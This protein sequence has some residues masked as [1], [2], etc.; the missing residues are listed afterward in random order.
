MTKT[1]L[2]S[3]SKSSLSASQCTQHIQKH[4]RWIL[5]E[6]PCPPTH[7]GHQVSQWKTSPKW[8]VTDR[9][10]FPREHTNCTESPYGF[11]LTPESWDHCLS[12]GSC[13]VVLPLDSEWCKIFGKTYAPSHM[14]TQWWKLH[15]GWIVPQYTSQGGFQEECGLFQKSGQ[16]P[17][18]EVNC[19]RPHTPVWLWHSS[20]CS[21]WSAINS[22][23]DLSVLKKDALL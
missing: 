2:E 21:A 6:T 18:P 19:C 12:H 15:G 23:L 16:R 11:P 7:P 20:L 3:E 22:C 5:S 14:H 8:V 10:M 9:W 17:K 1:L 4:F 13:P